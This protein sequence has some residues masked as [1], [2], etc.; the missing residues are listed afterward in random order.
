MSCLVLNYKTDRKKRFWSVLYEE[1]P[2][3]AKKYGKQILLLK[4][5]LIKIGFLF[6]Y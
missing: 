6:F 3:L 4:S 2:K 1:L 5:V